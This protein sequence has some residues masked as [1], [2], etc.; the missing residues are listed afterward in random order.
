MV[1]ELRAGHVDAPYLRS[2]G[3]AIDNEFTQ[4]LRTSGSTTRRWF[5]FLIILV[6]ARLFRAFQITASVHGMG[7]RAAAAPGVA[8]VGMAEV[9]VAAGAVA[10]AQAAQAGVLAVK[11]AG[12]GEGVQVENG[13]IVTAIQAAEAGT[14][15][16]IRVHVSGSFLERDPMRAAWK[17]FNRLRMQKTAERS[18]V[19]I[20][21]NLRKKRFAI[22]GDTGLHQKVGDEFW[23][24]VASQ[25]GADI[26][27]LG[28]P[29]EALVLAVN[30]VGEVLRKHFPAPEGAAKP[31]ELPDD[32]SRS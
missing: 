16:Q 7:A 12:L 14:I 4:R 32:V 20:Y 3:P 21:V 17:W 31:N 23:S 19:L 18:G 29:E 8:G 24:G 25:L 13:K 26:K 1:P 10:E 5:G 15:G 9:G 27:K 30:R 11:A 28:H 6:L 22:I 2:A